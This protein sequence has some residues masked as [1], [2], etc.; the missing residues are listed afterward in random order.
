MGQSKIKYS[1]LPQIDL[2]GIIIE[3]CTDKLK[4]IYYTPLHSNTL[5]FK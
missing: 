3:Y 2:A 5:K 4:T 1:Q